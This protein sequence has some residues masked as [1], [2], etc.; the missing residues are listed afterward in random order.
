MKVEILL[1]VE[2]QTIFIYDEL[3][4]QPTIVLKIN[5]TNCLDFMVFQVTGDGYEH[6][7]IYMRS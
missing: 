2:M 7:D 5:L 4:F 1:K 6:D 3:S